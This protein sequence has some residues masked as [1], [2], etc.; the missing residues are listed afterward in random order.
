MWDG[1]GMGWWDGHPG[2]GRGMVKAGW[3]HP[4]TFAC[5][6]RQAAVLHAC[7][8][9]KKL[10]SEVSVL[11]RADCCSPAFQQHEPAPVTRD[12]M[13]GWWDGE[14]VERGIVPSHITA[15]RKTE[16]K[17]GE[18]TARDLLRLLVQVEDRSLW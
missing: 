8:G 1:L 12:G 16:L 18:Q 9:S 7:T 5:E 10:Q 13:V 15:A 3:D 2:M 6:Y 4:I 17:L 14:M 11:Q